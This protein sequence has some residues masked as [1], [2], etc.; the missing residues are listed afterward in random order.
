MLFELYT[1]WGQNMKI[2]TVVITFL[3][4]GLLISS[5]IS[6]MIAESHKEDILNELREKRLQDIEKEISVP[7]PTGLYH[8]YQEMT[9]LLH[10]LADNHSDIM[11]L[12]SI[13]TT[14]EERD[15]WMVKL[16]DNVEEDESEPEVLL[17]GAHHGNEKP[18]FEV[19]IY[20]IQHMVINYTKE[21][22]DDDGDG[23]VNEDPIDGEDNDEDGLTDEDPSEDRVREVINNTEIF[24]IPMFNPDGVEAGTRKN[25]APNHGPFGFKGEITSYGVDLNRN[26]GYR[27]FFL[28]IFPELYLGSTHYNDNSNVYHGERPFSEAETRAIR[29]FVNSHQIEICLTYHTYGELILYPWGYTK[30]PALHKQKFVSIGEGIEKINKYALA[31]YIFLYPTLGDAC[32]WLYGRKGIIPYTIELGT[33][34]APGDPEVIREMSITHVGVN[35][36]ICE[37]AESL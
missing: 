8:T 22:T 31:Q 15:L 23:S 13:G 26:Y 36:Y 20:F 9:D 35:L 2:T 27:W 5:S 33:S 6:A 3:V 19:L 32:D 34:H 29:Q 18:S 1:I 30:L 25:C 11:S 16:S 28:F 7:T 14:Y 12:T 4:G 37:T 21:N 24:I 17:M 10:D